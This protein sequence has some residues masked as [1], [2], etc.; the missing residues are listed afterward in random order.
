MLS[1]SCYLVYIQD[2]MTPNHSGFQKF[3]AKKM[4][5]MRKR[6]IRDKISPYH[7]DTADTILD[8]MIYKIGLCIANKALKISKGKKV[9]VSH[10]SNAVKDIVMKK[11]GDI[12]DLSFNENVDV[13][14]KLMSKGKRFMEVYQDKPP[15]MRAVLKEIEISNPIK[16]FRDK[17]LGN[18]STIE[19]VIFLIGVLMYI[20]QMYLK[21]VNKVK[22]A[23]YE[24]YV[25]EQHVWEAYT[26][27]KRF[28]GDCFD[29]MTYEELGKLPKSKRSKSKSK[30]SKS[31]SKPSKSKS[32]NLNDCTVVELK[33]LAKNR[34]KTSYSKMRKAELVKLLKK[35]KVKAPAKKVSTKKEM[36]VVELRALCK[37]K[38]IRGYSKMRKDQLIKACK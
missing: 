16:M 1:F 28:F 31:K 5:K 32:K 10:V 2:N 13:W 23:E 7:D 26:V 9:T 36:T 34:G 21:E 18:N 22:F 17:Y 38:N 8:V 19:A 37:K 3:I 20:T 6:G 12:N 24:V 25:D 30:P 15:T 27:L 14:H 11:G 4:L 35:E 33:V 29:G